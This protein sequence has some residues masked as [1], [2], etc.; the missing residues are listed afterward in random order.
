VAAGIVPAGFV[1][2]MIP[3]AGAAHTTGLKKLRICRVA[4][5][6]V[7]ELISSVRACAMR[8]EIGVTNSMA[9]GNFIHR[10]LTR[11]SRRN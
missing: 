8:D 2:S 4:P 11:I 7:P 6:D 9:Q 3:K 5:G 10:F 1:P